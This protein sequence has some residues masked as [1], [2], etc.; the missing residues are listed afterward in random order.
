MKAALHFKLIE[1][2]FV[3]LDNGPLA[4]GARPGLLN[5]YK[6]MTKFESIANFETW[7]AWKREWVGNITGHELCQI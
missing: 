4:S 5:I 3:C 6:L 2:Y 1:A 7:I